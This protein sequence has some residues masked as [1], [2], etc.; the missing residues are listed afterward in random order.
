SPNP[1]TQTVPSG[2]QVTLHVSAVATGVLSYQWYAGAAG[3]TSNPLGTSAD[4]VVTVT[5]SQTYWCHVSAPSCNSGTSSLDSPLY[6]VASSC[7][8]ASIT[9]QP[10]ASPAV[11]GLGGSSTLTIAVSGTSPTVQWY[12]SQN[13]N[14]GSGT[15]LPVT[16]TS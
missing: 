13:V 16:P 5:G 11:I 14:V 3:V 6:S 2:T 8:T 10:T 9:T 15:S 7:T 12:T 1:A 4:Q